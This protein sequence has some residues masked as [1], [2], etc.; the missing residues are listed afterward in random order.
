MAIVLTLGWQYE[1]ATLER[2]VGARPLTNMTY[3]QLDVT[4]ER[5]AFAQPRLRRRG[6][7]IVDSSQTN[8]KD[9]G[10]WRDQ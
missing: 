10:E 2:F 8:A 3:P 1:T 7:T 5:A 4:M 9:W 6:Q